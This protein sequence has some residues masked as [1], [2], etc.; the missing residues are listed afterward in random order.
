MVRLRSTIAHLATWDDHDYGKNDA[1]AEFA[2]R[3]EARRLFLQF[4]NVPL[5]DVRHQ[6]EGVYHG[7]TLAPSGQRTQVILLDTRFFGSSLKPTDQR[8]AAGRERYLPDEDP[9]KTML[10]Q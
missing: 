2:G 1:G 5:A 8:N 3:H 9:G 7:Q 6:R 4:W 10:A